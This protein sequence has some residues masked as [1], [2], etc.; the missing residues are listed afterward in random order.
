MHRGGM[1]TLGGGSQQSAAAMLL[2]T[3]HQAAVTHTLH[4]LPIKIQLLTRKTKL[5]KERTLQLR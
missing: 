4:A 5:R 2:P 1:S 3:R